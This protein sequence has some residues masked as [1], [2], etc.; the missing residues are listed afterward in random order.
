MRSVGG[1]MSEVPVGYELPRVSPAEP[2]PSVS[3]VITRAGAE[4]VELLL[5]HRVSEMPSFPDF[6]S[7]PGGGIKEC[8]RG[9]ADAMEQLAGEEG[10]ALAGLMRELVEEVGLAPSGRGLMAVDEP[11]REEVLADA[12]SWLP[13][14]RDGIIPSNHTGFRLITRRT[15]PPLAPMRFDNRFYHLHAGASPP[16]PSLPAERSE[17]DA[18]R[19]LR[20]IDALSAWE[21]CEMRIPPPQI[22]LLRALATG[23]EEHAGDMQ[24]VAD[25]LAS[26]LPTGEHLIE[27]APG[28]ECVP[29]E[30]QTLPPA[31]HTNC[32]ILGE[33]GGEHLGVDPAAKDSAGLAYLERRVRSAEKAGGR[34]VATVFTHRHPDHIGDL[35]EIA[36]IYRAP[37]WASVETHDVIPECETDSVLSDGDELVLKGPS[38]SVSWTVLATPGHCPGHIAL[39][40]DVGVVSG[41]LAVVVGTILVP[42]ADG[43]MDDYLASLERVRDLSPPMLFPAHGP[44]SPTPGK[45]LEH[46]IS[47][48][49]ARHLRVLE[50]V[51]SG[52]TSLAEISESAYADTQG[53]HP[54]LKLDQTL[55]HLK[56]HEI[57]GDVRETVSGWEPA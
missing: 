54:I 26:D 36:S 19:W 51:K 12:D 50:A 5:C 48:R 41:D 47:H 8:D 40:S 55:S 18:I 34:I 4:G 2:K 56:S 38:G 30:T 35:K 9:A 53:A 3:A 27:F 13:L 28:V 7:F 42:S 32:Y 23:L 44:L 1:D 52:L 6:W 45:L 16:D 20:P 37:I 25:S 49:R 46:Y 24:A 29:L 21:S 33:R 10:A 15:T 43:D 22:T 17:F 31:T 39:A 57:A 11:V 14:A